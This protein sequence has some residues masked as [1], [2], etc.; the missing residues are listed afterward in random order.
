MSR[1]ALDQLARKLTRELSQRL[2]GGVVR[3]GVATWTWARGSGAS[4]GVEFMSL[5]EATRLLRAKVGYSGP[6]PKVGAITVPCLP[7]IGFG[8]ELTFHADEAAAVLE[9]LARLGAGDPWAQEGPYGNVWAEVHRGSTYEWTDLAWKVEREATGDKRPRPGFA[10][11]RKYGLA[12]L[13]V[14][15]EKLA[16]RLERRST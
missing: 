1:A 3:G 14:S 6:T 8:F 15:E 11:C 7:R 12:A 9:W 10:S 13:S 16:E 5:D 4:Y 2:P